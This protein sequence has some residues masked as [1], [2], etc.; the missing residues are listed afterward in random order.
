MFNSL[1][2]AFIA[3]KKNP[4]VLPKKKSEKEPS[5]NTISLLFLFLF[6]FGAFL[7]TLL[8]S[9]EISRN[10]MQHVANL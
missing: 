1:T 2:Y 6:L 8:I 4:R 10:Y 9:L 5:I 3:S 7:L